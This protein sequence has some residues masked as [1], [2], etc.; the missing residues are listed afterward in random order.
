MFNAT[1]Q[2]SHSNVA[3][4]SAMPMFV[5]ALLEMSKAIKPCNCTAISAEEGFKFLALAAD[6]APSR[7]QLAQK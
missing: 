3:A 5:K 7:R 4:I 6:V 1:N 2:P